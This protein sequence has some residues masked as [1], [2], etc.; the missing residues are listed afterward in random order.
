MGYCYTDPILVNAM[1]V[2]YC[3]AKIVDRGPSE[4]LQE[5]LFYLISANN[6]LGINLGI[7]NPL[8][9]E[10]SILLRHRVRR[11]DHAPSI[12]V[13]VAGP[14]RMTDLLFICRYH[15]LRDMIE[16][17]L[18]ELCGFLG[19]RLELEY[20]SWIDGV[21]EDGILD[22]DPKSFQFKKDRK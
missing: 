4:P 12:G 2:V 20:C 8:A 15:G 14:G 17:I 18:M 9:T 3:L 21:E 6:F 10:I 19:E 13:T 7:E 22:E 11:L 5:R 16:E 1:E